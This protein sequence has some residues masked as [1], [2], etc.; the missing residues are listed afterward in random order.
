[1]VDLWHYMQYWCWSPFG[2]GNGLSPVQHQLI[3]YLHQLY[4]LLSIGLLGTHFGERIFFQENAFEKVFYKKH[5]VLASTHRCKHFLQDDSE[6]RI[7]NFI[8]YHFFFTLFT[9]RSPTSKF[10]ISFPSSTFHTF[11]RPLI[12]AVA[13]NL[14]S[15]L[16]ATP[17]TE[18]WWPRK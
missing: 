14:E 3:H 12:S 16:N 7:V 9:S 5:L 10:Q 8:K 4:Y 2:S 13:R 1:M 6:H 18:S 15:W 17:V 11:T